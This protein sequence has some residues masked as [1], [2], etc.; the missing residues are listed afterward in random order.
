MD[1][2]KVNPDTGDLSNYA[3]LDFANAGSNK[4][5]FL[6]L[7]V[8]AG[9]N[10]YGTNAVYHQ[11]RAYPHAGMQSL[12]QGDHSF[13]PKGLAPSYPFYQNVSFP[14]PP[15]DPYGRSNPQ[16]ASFL[17]YQPPPMSPSEGKF[18]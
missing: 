8:H 15:A 17:N 1:F 10:I 13:S 14:G 5:A 7:S 16:N 2:A 9:A 4:S 18:H 6:E 12:Q 11:V 3:D